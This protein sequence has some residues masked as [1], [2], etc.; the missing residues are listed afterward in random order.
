MKTRLKP[1]HRA[2]LVAALGPG[3]VDLSTCALSDAA[4]VR[5]AASLIVDLRFTLKTANDRR[6]E[7]EAELGSLRAQRS[8]DLA[9]LAGALGRPL[10]HPNDPA[11]MGAL[12]SDVV[13]LREQANAVAAY[14]EEIN[15]LLRDE[16]AR[17]DT[18][19]AELHVLKGGAA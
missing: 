1:K 3:A 10:T 6:D 18:L 14:S 13:M 5:L 11:A 8:L 7:A 17:R 2:A 16:R 19:A 12:V 15:G 4:L 9:A